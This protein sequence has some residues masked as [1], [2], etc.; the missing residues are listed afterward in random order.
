MKSI[1]QHSNR[2][3]YTTVSSLLSLRVLFNDAAI[4]PVRDE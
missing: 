4:A 2:A 3:M 1:F